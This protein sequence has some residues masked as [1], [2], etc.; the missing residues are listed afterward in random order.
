MKK[1]HFLI[2]LSTSVCFSIIFLAIGCFQ[3]QTNGNPH[4]FMNVGLM[5]L[6]GGCLGGIFLKIA[7][8]DSPVSRLFY[9][10]VFFLMVIGINNVSDLMSPLTLCLCQFSYIVYF[11]LTSHESKTQDCVVV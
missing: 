6:C 10:A 5:L 9:L 7:P 1:K 2:V 8:Q 11:C 4:T 3:T